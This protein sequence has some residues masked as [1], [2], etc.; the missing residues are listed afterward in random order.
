MKVANFMKKIYKCTKRGAIVAIMEIKRNFF[1][2]EQKMPILTTPELRCSDCQLCG[3]A[4]WRE[5][6]YGKLYNISVRGHIPK[7]R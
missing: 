7:L 2:N 1:A 4:D 3:I 5:C 6:E